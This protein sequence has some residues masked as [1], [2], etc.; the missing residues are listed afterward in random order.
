MKN[1]NK[2]YLFLLTEIGMKKNFIFRRKIEVARKL[3]IANENRN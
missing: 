1:R 3:R 2:N